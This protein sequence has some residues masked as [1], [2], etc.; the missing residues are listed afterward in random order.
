MF[1]LSKWMNRLWSSLRLLFNSTLFLLLMHYCLCNKIGSFGWIWVDR[2]VHRFLK[3]ICKAWSTFIRVRIC[4]GLHHVLSLFFSF[5]S[6][7]LPKLFLSFGSL[8]LLLF[9]SFTSFLLHGNDMGCG[10]RSRSPLI[11]LLL[12]SVIVIISRHLLLSALLDEGSDRLR[13]WAWG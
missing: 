7:S 2:F 13:S 6:N 9:L 10:F 12:S 1:L 5:L 3:L 8:F 4:G 11:S